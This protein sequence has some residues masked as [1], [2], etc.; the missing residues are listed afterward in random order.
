MTFEKNMGKL[1]RQ[2]TLCK[3][4]DFRILMLH[5]NPLNTLKGRRRL[6]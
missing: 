3:R 4:Q 6:V 5:S 1:I 2:D